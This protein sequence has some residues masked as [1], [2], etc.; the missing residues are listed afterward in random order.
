MDQWRSGE[1]APR[2]GTRLNL[3]TGYGGHPVRHMVAKW[4]SRGQSGELVREDAPSTGARG[5]P[6]FAERAQ[7]VTTP[8]DPRHIRGTGQSNRTRAY[9]IRR[10]LPVSSE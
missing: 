1:V 10:T 7:S 4:R 8:T 5:Q 9:R 2:L 3:Q 6:P